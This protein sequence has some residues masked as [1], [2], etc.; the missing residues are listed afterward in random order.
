VQDEII[1]QVVASS[2]YNQFGARELERTLR[3][4]IEDKIV[5]LI[6]ENKVKEGDAI[7]L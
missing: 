3:Q 7:S 1:N 6:L 5:K 4:T 2:N